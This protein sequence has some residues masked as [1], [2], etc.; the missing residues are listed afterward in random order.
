MGFVV[1][2]AGREESGDFIGVIERCREEHR[3]C[4]IYK[5]AM[6][7][8]LQ[9]LSSTPTKR[10]DYCWT[11]SRSASHSFSQPLPTRGVVTYCAPLPDD[12]GPGHAFLIVACCCSRTRIAVFSF[13]AY[14][15]R[16]T[17]RSI[18]LRNPESFK[19]YS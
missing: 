17:R 16:S 7:G 2:L 8:E 14:A 15:D 9:R 3:L 1:R 13:P 19:R 5:I 12:P 11:C 6:T 10:S 18:R 4:K